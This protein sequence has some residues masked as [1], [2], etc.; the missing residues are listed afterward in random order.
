MT[1]VTP[2]WIVRV[3]PPLTVRL[4]VAIYGLHVLL[5]VPETVPDTKQAPWV[6]RGEAA[7]NKQSAERRTDERSGLGCF[8]RPGDLVVCISFPVISFSATL[9]RFG[10]RIVAV[11]KLSYLTRA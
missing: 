2:G 5:H 11:L 1:T 3:C 9:G 6:K 10:S 4:A 8:P 7:S